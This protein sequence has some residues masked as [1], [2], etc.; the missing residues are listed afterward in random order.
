MIRAASGDFSGVEG[1]AVVTGGSGGIG[2]AICELLALRGSD[3]AL[4]FRNN[5]EAAD[6]VVSAIEKTGRRATKA[7]VDVTDPDAVKGFV[8][9]A[10]GEF[11]AIHTAVSAAGPY[12]PMRYVSQ[13][14]PDLFREKVEADL[15]GAF[16][17]IWA[18]L[19]HL[20][21]SR[22][23]LVAV[24]SMAVRRF[25]V[26]DSLS[27][28]PKGAVEALVRAVA[29]EEGRFGIRANSVGPGM[30]AA[31]MYHE[32]V[33]RGDFTEELLTE[34]VANIALGRPGA[35]DDIAE[36]VCFLASERASY[37]TGKAIDVDGGYK[38]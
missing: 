4:S 24:T 31:G 26:K 18:V 14:E 25:P 16:H 21:Q 36:L 12:V 17:L 9:G 3:V 23:S 2:A 1:V 15:F 37:I 5:E 6:K 19:P 7:R 29:A 28:V 13:I 33:S 30:M 20:R 22:G 38:I 10:A 32:L 8:N 35:A 27:A 34:A 11:G